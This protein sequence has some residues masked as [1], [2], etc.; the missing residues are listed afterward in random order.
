MSNNAF[1]NCTSI[2]SACPVQAS[3][4]GYILNLGSNVFFAVLFT[5][6]LLGQ[7]FLG[8][9]HRCYQFLVAVGIGTLGEILG[10]AGRVM[11]HENP[12]SKTGNTIQV[13]CLILSPS[14]I[15]A[16]I[17]LTIRYLLAVFGSQYS[18]I[19]PR[20]YT[21]IFIGG[22]IASILTQVAGGGMAAGAN[23]GST[24][25]KVGNDLLIVGLVLQVITMVLCALLVI[26]YL[27]NFRREQQT[28]SVQLSGRSEYFRAQINHETHGWNRSKVRGVILTTLVAFVAVFIRCVYRYVS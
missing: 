13:V 3:S 18:M 26:N 14:F 8:V 7:F 2:T 24:S 20:L 17:Y 16:G 27:F 5:V 12:W 6:V 4:Y 11:L 19:K 15:T 23:N 28:D 9:R 22:D 10:Y 21:W 25:A 1:D